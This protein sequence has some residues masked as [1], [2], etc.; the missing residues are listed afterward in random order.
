MMTC[1]QLEALL[2]DYWSGAISVN[3][4]KEVDAH[5]AGCPACRK[6]TESLGRLWTGLGRMPAAESPSPALRARFYESLDA[7]RAGFEEK[8]PSRRFPLF[9]ASWWQWRHPAWLVTGAVALLAMGIF[10]GQ[11]F[12]FKKDDRQLA[13]LRGEVDKMRQLV[14][15]SLLQQQSASE[16]LQGVNWAYRVQK[17]DTEVVSAL[18]KTVREDQSV[19]VRLAAV[20]AL[21]PFAVSS[22]VVRTALQQSL[23]KQ[24]SPMVGLALIDL[25]VD[26]SD[27]SATPL[28]ERLS[29]DPNQPAEIRQRAHSAASEMQ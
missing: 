22:P 15:L 1:E 25:L 28:F 7:Y 13:Q 20:E 6:E 10:I 19:N 5:L 8:Q 12:E 26:L 2:P 23:A 4:Q 21:R 24:D 18:L 14:A 17:S 11:R 29:K 9:T 3:Q 16:R 27:R